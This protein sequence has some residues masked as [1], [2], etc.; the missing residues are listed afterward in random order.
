MKK[1]LILLI[2]LLLTGCEAAKGNLTST[3][4][5]EEV[6]EVSLKETYTLH[7]NSGS[8]NTIEVLKEYSGADVSSSINTYKALYE[9]YDGISVDA[10]TS[11]IKYTF[12]LSKIDK[13]LVET[14]NLYGTFSLY[15]NYNEEVKSLKKLG[16]TCD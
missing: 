13:S 7:Y 16:Y 11:T 3:C 12:D 1:Y 8:I 6:G 9:S 4:Y 5:K 14:L 10:T 2:V 15:D